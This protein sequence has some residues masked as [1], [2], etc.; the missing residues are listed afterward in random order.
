MISCSAQQSHEMQYHLVLIAESRRYLYLSM[1]LN[2]GGFPHSI[3]VFNFFIWFTIL[4]GSTVSQPALSFSYGIQFWIWFKIVTGSIISQINQRRACNIFNFGFD[5]RLW[6][7]QWF[8]KLI[9]NKGVKT[10][11]SYAPFQHLKRRSANM[12]CCSTNIVHA[13]SRAK[14]FPTLVLV[15]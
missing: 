9:N 3:R 8:F 6:L 11:H 5:S 1:L 7:G 13:T 15:D 2:F 10:H 4:T 14:N 12:S